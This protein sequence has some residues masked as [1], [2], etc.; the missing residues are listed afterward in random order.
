MNTL[1]KV[2]TQIRV[3]TAR[4]VRMKFNTAIKQLRA[5]DQSTKSNQFKANESPETRKELVVDTLESVK[6]RYENGQIFGKSIAVLYTIEFAVELHTLGHKNVV[7]L[8]KDFCKVTKWLANK[9]GFKSVSYTHLT[10]PT[11]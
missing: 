3:P 4:D 9:L 5:V 6:A 10:L 8:T 2:S 11:N 1:T 7:V